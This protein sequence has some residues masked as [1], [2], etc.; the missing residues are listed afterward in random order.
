MDIY[1]GDVF[2]ELKQIVN[3]TKYCN[4]WPGLESYHS[5]SQWIDG[6]YVKGTY[7]DST[8]PGPSDAGMSRTDT[9]TV[10]VMGYLKE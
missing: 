9:V 5:T 6:L 10:T 3:V 7:K 1:F 8:T 2:S 4:S